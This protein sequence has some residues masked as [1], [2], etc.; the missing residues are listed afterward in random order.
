LL[1]PFYLVWNSSNLV[2]V[3][4][5]LNT[6]LPPSKS[7]LTSI[8]YLKETLDRAEVIRSCITKCVVDKVISAYLA[9]LTLQY[10]GA[11][12]YRITYFRA[13]LVGKST[14]IDLRF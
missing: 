1:L 9:R 3:K 11:Y 13:L 8:R 4:V 2:Y 5:F 6:I 7:K 12:G 10:N 14:K